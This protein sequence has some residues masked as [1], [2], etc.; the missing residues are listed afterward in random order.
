MR[1]KDKQQSLFTSQL[2]K[3]C[4]LAILASGPSATHRVATLKLNNYRLQFLKLRENFLIHTT[5]RA[6]IDLLLENVGPLFAAG[7]HA[8]LI[9]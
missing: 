1:S 4:Q 3:L 8:D 5:G 7:F 9:I 2:P 6:V